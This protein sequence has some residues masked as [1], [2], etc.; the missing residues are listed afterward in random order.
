M[1][2]DQLLDILGAAGPFGFRY[3]ISGRGRE[4]AARLLEVSGYIGPAPVSLEAYTAMIEWQH[5]RAP[6]VTREQRDRLPLGAGSHRGDALM[7]GL[8]ASSGRSL[9]VFGPAGNGK[10]T[11]GRLIHRALQ[12]DIWVPHCIAIEENVIRV[13]D[14]QLHQ[15]VEAA[16]P[17]PGRS[18]NAG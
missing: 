13:Y 9:F 3:A 8:A 6:K 15:A 18:I 12:G 14:P 7:A 5:A 17:A 10:T 11:L 16:N 2:N 4:R 1:R